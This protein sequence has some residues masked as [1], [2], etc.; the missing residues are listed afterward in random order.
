MNIHKQDTNIAATFIILM[1]ILVIVLGT[2]SGCTTSPVPNITIGGGKTSTDGTCTPQTV[3]I[4]IV[5]E[6]D[7]A[8]I[9]EGDVNDEDSGLKEPTL[10]L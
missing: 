6:T 10:G 8:I 1:V 7:K 2:M 9:G 5:N 4:N 3:T